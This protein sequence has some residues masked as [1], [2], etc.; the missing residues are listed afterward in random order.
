MNSDHSSIYLEKSEKI[1]YKKSYTRNITLVKKHTDW[2]NFKVELDINVDLRVPLKTPEQL[3]LDLGKFITL[4]DWTDALE[5][6]TRN[7]V[8]DHD[9]K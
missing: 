1:L 8:K 7:K 3:N 9:K 6:H 2:E 5:K 4:I